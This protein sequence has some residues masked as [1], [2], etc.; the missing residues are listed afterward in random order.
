VGLIGGGVIAVALAGVWLWNS[1]HDTQATDAAKGPAPVPELVELATDRSNSFRVTDEGMKIL[2]IK[3]TEVRPAPPPEPLRLPG[4]I[5]MDQQRMVRVHS[6]FAGEVVKIGTTNE[7]VVGADK[8]VQSRPRTLRYGDRV[9]AGQV[10]AVIWSKDIGEKKGELL[11]AVIKRDID[12]KLFERLKQAEK[13]IVPQRTIDEAQRDYEQDVVAVTTAERTLLSWRITTEELDAVWKEARDVQ[14]H[15]A[16]DK[17]L[18]KVWAE[19]EVRSPIE[20]TIVEKNYNV[21]DIVTDSAQDLFKVADMSRVFVLANAYEEDLPA[22]RALKPEQR[23]WKIDV[24]ADPNDIPVPG[25]FDLIGN[26]VDPSQHSAAIMGSLDNVAGKLSIGQFITATVDLPPDPTMVSLPVNSLIEQGDDTYVLVEVSGERHEFVR[27]QV[28][29]TR[30]GRTTAFVRSEPTSAERREGDEALEAGEH[31]ITSSVL[32]LAAQ[33]DDLKQDA[34]DNGPK[35]APETPAAQ[36][37]AAETA[38]G[39]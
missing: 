36:S 24:K 25:R 9:K 13:G 4:S 38:S 16:V 31:V 1:T 29:V 26:I 19:T 21:G 33:L 37:P 22:L 34:T 23:T 27:R 18:A 8:K 10:L 32:E 3:T 30:R 35:T 7:I 5:I 14:T 39:K 15:A 2:S 11:N 20:G 17:N 6:R 12:R 28:A